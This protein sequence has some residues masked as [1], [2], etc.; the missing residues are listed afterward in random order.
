MD[1]NIVSATGEGKTLLSAF[2]NALQKAGVYNYNLITL[3]S[4]IPPGSRIIM[5]TTY[6]TPDCEFGHK[7]YVIK[8]EMRSQKKGEYVCAGMGWYGLDD[9]RG[10]FVEHELKG[11]NKSQVQSHIHDLIYHSLE[12]LCTFRGIFFNKNHVKS[13]IAITCVKDRPACALVLAI[14]KSEGWKES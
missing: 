13:S 12:D 4:I 5:T 1:I 3:S 8:A 11:K 2:D 6:T 10:F 9:G 7:L 14:Y